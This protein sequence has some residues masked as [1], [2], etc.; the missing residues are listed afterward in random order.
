VVVAAAVGKWVLVAAEVAPEPTGL[1]VRLTGAT[2]AAK[3][4][5]APAAAELAGLHPEGGAW[6]QSRPPE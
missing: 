2:F 3:C 5:A 6:Q 1:A 4:D